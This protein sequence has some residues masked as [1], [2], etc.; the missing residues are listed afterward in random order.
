MHVDGQ[1]HCGSIRYEAEVDPARVAICHCTD[2]QVL[3][4]SPYRVSVVVPGDAFRL[5]AGEPRVYVKVAESGNR[6]AHAFCPVCGTPVFA[7]PE[8]DPPQTYTLRIGNL[9]QRADLPPRRQI[10]C[11]SSLEWAKDIRDVPS[12][13]RQ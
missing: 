9:A 4:G 2:C 6:R 1:C 3:T 12:S 8:S 7:R 11:R 5:L 13:A 10:W